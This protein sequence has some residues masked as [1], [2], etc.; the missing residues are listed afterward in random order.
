MIASPGDV[1]REKR[2]AIRVVHE[3]NAVHS[4][5]RSIVLMPTT[6]ESHA[7]PEMGE[8]PQSVINRQILQDCD[9]LVAIFWTRLGSPTGRSPSGTVEE[10]E[11]HLAANKPVMMYFSTAP[12]HPDSVEASQLQALRDFRQSCKKRGLVQEFAS[13]GEFQQVF[14]RQLAQTVIRSFEHLSEEPS[15]TALESTGSPLP[16]LSQAA[17]ELLVE[18]VDAT[19]GSILCVRSMSGLHV[20]AGGRDFVSEGDA[21][22]EALWMAAVKELVEEGLIAD[23]GHKGEVFRVTQAGYSVADALG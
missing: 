6:W 11:E 13:I 20:Q 8:R 22:S 10:V 18:A 2:A 16:Q 19:D 14:T 3:W 4:G 12:V 1:E 7:S 21:R 9:L 5:D 15:E 17:K 23:L